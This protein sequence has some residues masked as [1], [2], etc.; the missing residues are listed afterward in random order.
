MRLRRRFA[1]QPRGGMS[2]YDLVRGSEGE[3]AADVAFANDVVA[4]D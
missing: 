4:H 3:D 2:G 1:T